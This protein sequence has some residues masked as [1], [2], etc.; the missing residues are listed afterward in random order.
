MT[1]IDCKF[2]FTIPV[3]VTCFSMN[4][5]AIIFKLLKSKPRIKI[6]VKE[7][8]PNKSTEQNLTCVASED[9]PITNSVYYA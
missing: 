6:Q 7:A 1:I 2:N 5:H 9:L 8:N 3:V 4:L